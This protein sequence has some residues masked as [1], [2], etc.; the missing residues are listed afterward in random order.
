MR[1]M[2][3]QT[4]RI[5]SRPYIRITRSPHKCV[6]IERSFFITFIVCQRYVTQKK[7]FT[8]SSVIIDRV[9]MITLASSD[10]QKCVRR[11]YDPNYGAVI[12]F[13][14]CQDRNRWEELRALRTSVVCAVSVTLPMS[15]IS[16][17]IASLSLNIYIY[18]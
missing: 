10:R 12:P 13:F 15:V 4:I 17:V 5:I 18:I 7:S 1:S 8:R 14:V 16:N 3:I 6:Q 11:E 9:R 2:H